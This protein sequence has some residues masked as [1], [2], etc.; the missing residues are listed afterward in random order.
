M[1]T[2]LDPAALLEVLEG[3]RRLTL[4]TIEAFPEE[5]LFAFR[6]VPRL[7]PFAE[8]VKEILDMEDGYVRGIATGEWTL[9][10]T[11]AGVRTKADLLAACAR[12][13]QRTREL[14]PRLTVERLLAVEPD[15]FWGGPPE[16]HFACL[17]YALENEIH[18]RGQ[19]YAYLRLLGSE[20]PTCYE[21]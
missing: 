5:E 13:R 6:P 15:P 20:P 21:R 8:M 10:D 11:C 17:L 19:A 14:R 3:N 7:R 18:H 12:V 2:L 9:E 4:R 1:P 16:T